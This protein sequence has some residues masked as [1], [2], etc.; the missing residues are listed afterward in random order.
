MIKP[1][2]LMAN[3]KKKKFLHPRSGSWEHKTQNTYDFS[4]LFFDETKSLV[5]M[6]VFRGFPCRDSFPTSLFWSLDK[7]N[8]KYTQNVLR[9]RDLESL[10][11]DPQSYVCHF[12]QCVLHILCC[13]TLPT[14]AM[15]KPVP[16]F[17]HRRL[18]CGKEILSVGALSSDQKDSVYQIFSLGIRRWGWC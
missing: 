18:Q 11:I 1:H 10:M 15:L 5:Q 2:W 7:G 8:P 14:N 16:R 17:F 4:P 3:N 12:Y 9:K 13:P 6:T